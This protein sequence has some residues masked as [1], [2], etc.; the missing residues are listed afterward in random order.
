MNA[1]E[2]LH[3]RVSCPLLEEPGPTQQQLDNMFQAA[4]RSPDHAGLHPW[5]FLLVS[6]EQ[7]EQLGELYLEAALRGNPELSVERQEK[8]RR[9]PLRA[10]TMVV[11]IARLCEHPKVP[12]SEMLISA[13][14]AAQN[15]LH[16]AHAQGIGAMWRTGELAYDAHVK[17]GL[18]L[19]DS[20]EIVGYIYLGTPARIRKVPQLEQDDYV[21]TWQRS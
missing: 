5:R 7:R 20:E 18:G 13:G 10:P 4:L 8:T 21:Q 1:I 12:Q 3:N 6:G 9:M 15:I 14:C 16:A 11:V 17:S 2:A 19:T